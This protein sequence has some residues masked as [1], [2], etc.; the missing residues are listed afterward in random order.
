MIMCFMNVTSS[1]LQFVEVGSIHSID[2]ETA[3]E[4]TVPQACEHTSQGLGPGLTGWLVK[5]E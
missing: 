4:V 1:S 2:E 3:R 5:I